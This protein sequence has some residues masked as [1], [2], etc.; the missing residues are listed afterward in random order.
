MLP[1]SLALSPDL[2]ASP[3]HAM[4]ARVLI[5]HWEL[6]LAL[7]TAWATLQLGT[8]RERGREDGLTLIPLAVHTCGSWWWFKASLLALTLSYSRV[9][10]YTR[11]TRLDRQEAVLPLGLPLSPQN[12]P[13]A[14]DSVVLI[15][16]PI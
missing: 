15:H 1:I 11:E 16:W 3:V 8:C 9:S 7:P 12:W 2:L 10:C 14:I 5:H 4:A 6:I 13:K